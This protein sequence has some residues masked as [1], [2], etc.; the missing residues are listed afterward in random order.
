MKHLKKNC[1]KGQEY[2]STD[3][4]K[5]VKGGYK[6]PTGCEGKSKE[7]CG[8]SCVADGIYEGTCGWSEGNYN[9]CTCGYVTLR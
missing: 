1:M 8:G 7:A 2:L 6:I 3:E 9:R 4:M 5:L